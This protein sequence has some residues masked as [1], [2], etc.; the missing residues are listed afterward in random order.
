[1]SLNTD[2]TSHR[3]AVLDDWQ[4]AARASADWSQISTR[5]AL[6]FFGAPFADEDEA[7]EKLASFDIILAMRER[8]PFPASLIRR[9]PRLRM[10]GLTGSRAAL[11]DMAFMLEHGITVCH[12]DS[13]P[14]VESTAEL[15]LALVLAAARDIPAASAAVRAGDFQRGTKPGLLLAGKTLGVIGLGKIGVRLTAFGNALGMKVQAWSQNMTAEQAEAA[16]AAFASK[17]ELLSTSD[18]ISLHLVLSERTLGLIGRDELAKMKHGAILVNTSRAKLIDEAALI[19]AVKAQRVVAALDVFD[20]EPLSSD[21]PLASLR[22]AVLTPHL[23]YSTREVFA[24][25]YSQLV[26]NTLAY[27]D[28]NPIRTMGR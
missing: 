9:L 27:L 21:H 28:G 25:F 7:A 3:V 5:A 8:T 20:Q 26:E 2:T 18:V 14:G 15:A 23:G 16:G 22:N 10:F 4:D 13:G 24:G 11:V 6:E 19:E 1:M 17:D 12:T